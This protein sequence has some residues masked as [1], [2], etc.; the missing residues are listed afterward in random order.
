MCFRE[1]NNDGSTRGYTVFHDVNL[2]LLT[3]TNIYT[4]AEILLKVITVFH[5]ENLAL[6]RVTSTHS[7]QKTQKSKLQNK[8]K[9]DRRFKA[10]TN[11]SKDRE[12]EFINKDV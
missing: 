9:S 5:S 10:Q 7:I 2:A 12:I 4:K 1:N 11:R 8:M 3:V 6:L